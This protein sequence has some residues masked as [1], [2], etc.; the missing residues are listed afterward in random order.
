MWLP[1]MA[2][3]SAS[4]F[5]CSVSSVK[6]TTRYAPS[7]RS[8]KISNITFFSSVICEALNSYRLLWLCLIPTLP[9]EGRAG[10]PLRRLHLRA[11]LRLK[12]GQVPVDLAHRGVALCNVFAIALKEVVDRLNANFDGPRRLVLIEVFE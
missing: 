12:A 5:S 2:S 7:S 3:E 1:C 8:R 11:E 9:R 6:Y 4:S 10:A